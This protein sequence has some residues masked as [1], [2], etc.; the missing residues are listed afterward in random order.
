MPLLTKSVALGLGLAFVPAANCLQ[1][2]S[3]NKYTRQGSEMMAWDGDDGEEESQS[4]VA[5]LVTGSVESLALT[6]LLGNVVQANARK[7][8]QVDLYFA[9]RGRSSP[10]ETTNPKMVNLRK[11]FDEVSYGG[12]LMDYICELAKKEGAT[13]CSWMA[14]SDEAAPVGAA[15]RSIMVQQ[16]AGS[17]SGQEAVRRWRSQA[18]LWA[19]VRLE[20]E[21]GSELAD[22]YDQYDA[23]MVTRSDT[24]FLAPFLVDAEGFQLESQRVSTT[25][26]L[27]VTGISDK[28]VVMG[29]E[30]AEVLLG[31]HEAWK[32]GEE[33]LSGTRTAEEVWFRMASHGGLN[34]VPEPMYAA[35]ALY[36]ASGL[37]CFQE[38]TFNVNSEQQRLEQCFAESAGEAPVTSLFSAFSCETMDPNFFDLLWP[39]QVSR[40]HQVI[41]D[42]TNRNE[43]NAIVLAVIDHDEVELAVKMLTSLQAAGEDAK[44]VVVGTSAGVCKAL[45]NTAGVAGHKCFVVVPAQDVRLSVFK[46]AI[47]TT[48]AA[49]G[50]SDKIVYASPRATFASSLASQLAAS[51]K[52]ILFGKSTASSGACSV[53]AGSLDEIDGSVLYL[54]DAPEVTDMLLRAWQAMDESQS[55]SQGRA[56][57]GALDAS[58]YS[59]FGFLSCGMRLSEEPESDRV[60][61]ADSPPG[62]TEQIAREVRKASESTW[63]DRFRAEASKER[64]AKKDGAVTERQRQQAWQTMADEWKETWAKRVA[65]LQ[66]ANNYNATEV[67]EERRKRRMEQRK[68]KKATHKKHV[69]YLPP[70]EAAKVKARE[71][72]W[73]ADIQKQRSEDLANKKAREEAF[74]REVQKAQDAIYHNFEENAKD[75]DGF[76][77]PSDVL[78][79]LSA[80]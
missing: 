41:A 67:A 63:V 59:N 62:V 73:E 46:H 72:K 31:V 77:A 68:A 52:R 42:I 80:R 19:A 49:A 53:E 7:G 33:R 24:Y 64:R 28:A 21:A 23:V 30:A 57:A 76:D 70:D 16:P 3:G 51:D 18:H 36:T 66:E 25:P 50:L 29:R 26:C 39:Q 22:Q 1:V 12:K 15:Q 32:R 9:L 2:D 54:S 11:S 37:P 13:K 74:R 45:A 44:S 69:R 75:A 40:L 27:D 5:V 38:S 17:A 61:E 8:L 56:L 71:D 6:P 14:P 48:V 47:L 34:I 35:Q 58:G 65:D 60:V 79:T 20:E 10:G 55:I 43:S 78:G 4:R